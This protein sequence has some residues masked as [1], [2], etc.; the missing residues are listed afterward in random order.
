M[1]DW[2]DLSAS[3]DVET[4]RKIMAIRL[5][6]S[7]F[8]VCH[9]KCFSVSVVELTYL[10]SISLI[11]FLTLCFRLTLGHLT[12]CLKRIFTKSNTYRT[13]LGSFDDSISLLNVHTLECV[14]WCRVQHLFLYLRYDQLITFTA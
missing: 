6:L 2:I 14:T 7:L 5:W 8:L 13:I 4:K 12:V 11:N 9:G 3:Q 10:D 1:G